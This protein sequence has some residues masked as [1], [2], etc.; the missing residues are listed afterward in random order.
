[1]LERMLLKRV[2]V[3]VQRLENVTKKRSIRIDT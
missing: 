2:S 1:V 3:D